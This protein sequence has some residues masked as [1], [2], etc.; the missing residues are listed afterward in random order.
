MQAMQQLDPTSR[1][2]WGDHPS[3]VFVIGE[4]VGVPVARPSGDNTEAVIAALRGIVGSHSLGAALEAGEIIFRHV[5]GGDEYL[6]RGRGK[7]C[8]SF[9]RLAAHPDLEMSTSSLWRAVAIFELSLRFPELTQYLHVGVAHVSVVLGL[10][11]AEQ[12]VLLREAELRRWT[13]RK[14]QKLATEARLRQRACG[15]LPCARVVESLAG[16]ELLVRDA[17]LDRQLGLMTN[18]EAS[19]ALFTLQ[20]IQQRVVEVE[21]RLRQVAGA[22]REWR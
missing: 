17:G 7:K 21:L 6:L 11:Q 3:G 8:S 12:F 13:R 19:Q 15:V 16:L 14:L 2:S 22:Y 10:P 9:R 20:R 4:R 18:S 1:E 5:F